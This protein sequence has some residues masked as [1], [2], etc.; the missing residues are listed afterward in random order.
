MNF[1]CENVN[2]LS[3]IFSRYRHTRGCQA[4]NDEA[5][6]SSATALFDNL[7]NVESTSHV[8]LI[9]RAHGSIKVAWCLIQKD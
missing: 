9:L 6:L 2:G 4:R 5:T 7:L 3:S 8:V 1:H